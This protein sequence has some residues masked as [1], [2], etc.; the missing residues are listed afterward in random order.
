MLG[1]LQSA[2][3]FR[4]PD[5]AVTCTEEPQTNVEFSAKFSLRAILIVRAFFHLLAENVRNT[6]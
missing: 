3:R 6:L 2:I 4:R 5:I 1:L